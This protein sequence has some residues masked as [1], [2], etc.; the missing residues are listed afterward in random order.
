MYFRQAF[1][2]AHFITIIFSISPYFYFHTDKQEN[3]VIMSLFSMLNHD[4]GHGVYW[5]IIVINDLTN[6]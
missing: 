3:Q 4:R 2:I 6:V 1:I 5:I